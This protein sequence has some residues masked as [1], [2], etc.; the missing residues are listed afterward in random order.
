MAKVVHT[1]I[2]LIPSFFFN[3]YTVLEKSKVPHIQRE[4]VYI[5]DIYIYIWPKHPWVHKQ[6]TPTQRIC[7]KMWKQASGAPRIK[8]ASNHLQSPDMKKYDTQIPQWWKFN[9][10]F[11]KKKLSAC[12]YTYQPLILIKDKFLLHMHMHTYT[13]TCMRACVCFYRVCVRVREILI[14]WG[15]WTFLMSKKLLNH[16]SI[17]SLYY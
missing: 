3:F 2:Y 12:F 16:N 7:H 17:M 6:V 8:W 14:R 15:F 1:S 10:Q 9:S 11:K 4:R 5:D 13:H